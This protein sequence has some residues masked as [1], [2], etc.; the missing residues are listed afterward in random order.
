MLKNFLTITTIFVIALI[1]CAR[2]PSFAGEGFYEKAD[3]PK[4][5]NSA[6]E[7]TFLIYPLSGE[8]GSGTGFLIKKF[9]HPDPNYVFLHLLSV[10]HVIIKNCGD[11]LGYC[12]NLMIT[13]SHAYD[14]EN[15]RFVPIE[16][17]YRT[18]FGAR[19][20]RRD[21]QADLSIIEVVAEKNLINDIRPVP[22]VKDCTLFKRQQM[23]LIGFPSTS[24]RT[25]KNTLPIKS[26]NLIT[27]RWSQGLITEYINSDK[28]YDS[29]TSYWIGSTADNL[30]GLSGGPALNEAGEFFS[31]VDSATSTLENIYM[32]IES[33]ESL[34]FH[35][36]LTRCE[37]VRDFLG[38]RRRSLLKG[39]TPYFMK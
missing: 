33:E 26:K 16:V 34:E 28:N 5:L 10:D 37:L 24:D 2:F 30:S 20:L 25:D 39:E 27:K 18:F 7:S 17:R 1:T 11:T 23:Y 21:K 36:L 22:F 8:G 6:W 29:N 9:P 15:K 3:L 35:S 14:E 12:D 31:V 19:V 13:A 32:G 4:E 38:N